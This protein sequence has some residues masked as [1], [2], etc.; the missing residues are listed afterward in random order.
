MKKIFG[1]LVVLLLFLTINIKNTYAY[2]YTITKGYYV[3]DS[4]PEL[5]HYTSNIPG[6]PMIYCIHPGRPYGSGASSYD[7][8]LSSMNPSEVP[9]GSTEYKYRIAVMYA[10]QQMKAKGWDVNTNENYIN[11]NTVFR[12][13]RRQFYANGECIGTCRQKGRDLYTAYHAYDSWGAGIKYRSRVTEA[14]VLA[15]QATNFAW[16]NGN[17][18]FEDIIANNLIQGITWSVV[19]AS[20]QQN[21]NLYELKVEIQPNSNEIYSV[22]YS[23]FK[24]SF[25]NATAKIISQSTVQG[26]GNNAI[27][28]VVFDGATWDKQD[29]AAYIE[30]N[31]CDPNSSASMIYRLSRGNNV[32]EMIAIL[33]S[34]AGSCTSGGG[35]IPR[36]PH[37]TTRTSV[38][39]SKIQ[40]NNTCSCDH[41]TG[42][43]TYRKFK[44]GQLVLEKSWEYGKDA[45]SEL[46]AEDLK[47][48]PNTCEKDRTCSKDGDKYYCKDHDG[49]GV[50]DECTKDDYVKDCL[51][52]Q[53]SIDDNGQHYCNDHD[54]DGGGD[55]CDE[56]Q[57]VEDCEC[58]KLEDECET[59]PSSPS[60]EEYDK[61]CLNCNP[62]VTIPSD[63]SDLQEYDAYQ[64]QLYQSKYTG[65]I[66]DISKKPTECNKNKA[67]SIKSCVIGK[68]DASQESYE[69]KTTFKDI[70]TSGDGGNKYC[71]VWCEESYDFGLP[72]AQRTVSG[73]YFTLLTDVKGT[74][75]CYTSSARDSEQPIDNELFESDLEAKRKEVIDAWN[76][77]S[78][79]K[80]ANEKEATHTT[81]KKEEPGCS[82]D[83][84]DTC[85]PPTPGY[86]HSGDSAEYEH[87]EESWSFVVYNENGKRDVV[88]S[89]KGLD[90]ENYVAHVSSGYASCTSC[91]SSGD[92]SCTPYNGTDPDPNQATE[93]N[94]AKATLNKK[95]QEFNDIIAEYNSC[96]GNLN[97]A[98]GWTN[99]MKFD[100]E[101]TFSY[102]E[103]YLEKDDEN[104][105]FVIDGAQSVPSGTETYCDGDTDRSY[106]CKSASATSHDNNVPDEMKTT[107]RKFM[108]NESGCNEFDY[109]VSKAKWVKKEKTVTQSYKSGA[110]FSTYTQYGTIRKTVNVE[111]KKEYYLY[112]PLPDGAFPISLIQK[113]GVFPFTITFNNIGQSNVNGTLGRLIGQKY[114][115]SAGLGDILTSYNSLDASKKCD[116]EGNKSNK[117]QTATTQSG[118]VCHYINNCDTCKF[119]CE[120]DDCVFDENCT[121]CKFKC[122][123]CIFDGYGTTY[124]YRTVSLNKLFP[125]DRPLGYNWNNNIKG[126]LT[127][128]DIEDQDAPESIYEHPQYSF[129]LT[130]VNLQK[131]RNYND[132]AGSYTNSN[133]PD[134][135]ASKFDG[136]TSS[137]YCENLTVNGV[138]YSI[139]CKSRFLDLIESSGKEYAND[140]YRVTSDHN[141]W[142]LFDESNCTS[143]YGKGNCVG[144]GP[145]WKLR[146]V[147]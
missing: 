44:N 11:G 115:T 142:V 130:P 28:T 67:N 129:T 109:T 58:P 72:T 64:G 30:T 41:Q 124:S 120:D 22:N 42:Y 134:Q 65:G 138:N 122:D 77:Y 79:W 15:Q 8:T 101:I 50:G 86:S 2:T 59:D 144:I 114:K 3:V 141:P 49:D 62:T 99:D 78:Y 23:A 73:G 112:T 18:S 7:Y 103:G 81:E 45:P 63:C 29:L 113:T 132:L 146:S 46:T 47:Q 93:L 139:N 84:C 88:S 53:C 74:R 20:L 31:Y 26:N 127:R 19:N 131:I 94:N 1:G 24:I 80:G 39:F 125:N 54:G 6:N 57:Y 100:P 147:D 85:N 97:G 133:I 76:I 117:T 82:A 71:K 27:T 38:P 60:C 32:Q 37:T 90:G 34:N 116:L 56:D 48:C 43:Y 83:A 106:N 143:G 111:G 128:K 137:L 21:N 55:K 136:E 98:T 91:S 69:N 17:R 123:T 14:I 96:S 95:I 9:V 89:Y 25:L 70:K 104:G 108:C 35:S 36:H 4:T 66:S 75:T 105:K 110:D 118:Y 16:T 119:K 13:I 92:A 51:K 140:V 87:Y 33:P 135:F 121:E 68:V 10:Y 126:E 5:R 107:I 61:K 12:L 52:P 145:S 102:N 40:Q